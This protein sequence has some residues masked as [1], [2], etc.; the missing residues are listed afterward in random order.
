M[1]NLDVLSAYLCKSHV[2][3]TVYHRN[4]NELRPEVGCDM[5]AIVARPSDQHRHKKSGYI[6]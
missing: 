5:D 1:G 3:L 4:K 2:Y 6:I